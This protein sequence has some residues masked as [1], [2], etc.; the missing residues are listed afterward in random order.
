[1]SKERSDQLAALN[2]NYPHPR[3]YVLADGKNMYNISYAQWDNG[4]TMEMHRHN[5][6]KIVFGG[7]KIDIAGPDSQLRTEFSSDDKSIFAEVFLEASPRNYVL[8]FKDKP[9]EEQY[10][11][12][13]EIGS[14]VM[15]ASV[16]GDSKLMVYKNNSKTFSAEFAIPVYGKEIAS[17]EAFG[18]DRTYGDLEKLKG[19]MSY[20]DNVTEGKHEVHLEVWAG[21]GGGQSSETAIAAGDFTYVQKNVTSMFTPADGAN[22]TKDDGVTTE[23]GK[24]NKGKIVFSKTRLDANS[25]QA[26]VVNSFD[27]TDPMYGRAYLGTSMVNYKVFLGGPEPQKNTPGSFYIYIQVDDQEKQ[28]LTQSSMDGELSKKTNFNIL[29]RGTGNDGLGTDE[30]YIA[31]INA[32]PEGEHKIRL[33]VWAGNGFTSGSMGAIA[34]GSFTLVKKAGAK[35]S[36][37]RTFASITPGMVNPTMEAQALKSLSERGKAAGWEEKFNAVKIMS[38]D[39]ETIRNELTSVIEGRIVEVMALLS[40]PDGHCAVQQFTMWEDYTGSGYSNTMIVNGL[41]ARNE[42]DCK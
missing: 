22:Y 13:N 29:L 28:M 33:E 21:D 6:A 38:S 25:T 23:M 10:K 7:S 40:F 3:F 42:V 18:G 37:G 36:L 14:I 30:S 31:L 11:R 20:L 2:A 9:A 26:Q 27:I 35:A 1:M 15:Y 32:L 39:W 34:T 16:D 8:Y 41:G 5:P 19:L 17:Y 4:Y 12:P 24:N